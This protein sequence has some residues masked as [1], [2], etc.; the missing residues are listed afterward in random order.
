M[1]KVLNFLLG[2]IIAFL[3]AYLCGSLLMSY[4]TK[5]GLLET[6]QSFKVNNVWGKV[7]SIGAIPNILLFYILLNKNNYMAARGVIFSFVFI[8]LFVFW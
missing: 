5:I 8:A 6:M 4:W 1:N 3:V 2:L 7:L